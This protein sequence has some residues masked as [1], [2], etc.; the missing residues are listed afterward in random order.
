MG[1]DP[2]GKNKD[3]GVLV[4]WGSCSKVP[5]TEW[6]IDRNVLSCRSGGLKSKIKVSTGSIPSEANAGLSPWLSG[7]SLLRASSHYMRSRHVCL[8]G[9]VFPFFKDTSHMGLGFT[10]MSSF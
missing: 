1:W 9:S 7:G 4:F 5:H 8:S 10:V 2:T 6:L 3:E